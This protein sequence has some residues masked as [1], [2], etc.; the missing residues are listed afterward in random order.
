LHAPTRLAW[1]TNRDPTAPPRPPPN[2]VITRAPKVIGRTFAGSV[3]D[4]RLVMER[5]PKS[6]EEVLGS[7]A[8]SF[9]RHCEDT[10][11]SSIGGRGRFWSNDGF[12]TSL[13]E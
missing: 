11:L 8:G 7:I 1:T 3:Y 4:K 9:L 6:L 10:E 12:V 5:V 2:H 13:V